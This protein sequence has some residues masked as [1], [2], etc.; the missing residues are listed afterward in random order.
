MKKLLKKPILSLLLLLFLLI[1]LPFIFAKAKPVPAPVSGNKIATIEN[2]AAIISKLYDSL[3]LNTL[4]LTKMAFVEGFKG[5]ESLRN[6]GKL[7]NEEILTI[8]DFSLPSNQKR[9]FVLDMEKLKVLYKTYVAHGR[10]SGT[11]FAKSFS[12]RPESNMSSPGFYVT[13]ETYTGQHGLSLKLHG[14]EKGINDNAMNRAIVIHPADYVSEKTIKALGYL[15][16]SLGCP[17]LP[18]QF[19]K[20]II[21]TIKNGSCFFIFSPNQKYLS[22]SKIL[23]QAS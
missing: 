1:H 9:L 10:N 8:A 4:G 18:P 12:N 21:E 5:F 15:G 3:Q 17:A 13:Q 19:A 23:Q 11:T 20:P 2:T 6:D 16:R 7:N 22:R 14:E